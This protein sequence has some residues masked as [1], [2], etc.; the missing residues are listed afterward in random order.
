MKNFLSSADLAIWLVMI[1]GKVVL[2]LCILKKNLVR[3]LPWVS[4][5][6]FASTIKSLFLLALAFLA[7]YTVYYYSFFVANFMLSAIA[8]LT[9]LEFWRQV[10]PGFNLPHN[11]QALGSFLAAMAGVAIFATLWPVKYPENRIELATYLVIAVAFIFI[12][13]Y[14]RYLGLYW[15][16]LVGGVS[17][18]LGVLY[19]V[20]GIV[21]AVMWHYSHF[22]FLP[23]R[24]IS[25]IVS[26]VAAV[27]WTIV[28]LS[29]WGE[30]EITE[31][32]LLKLGQ[33]VDHMETDFIG[34]VRNG[35]FLTGGKK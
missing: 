25:E 10:L 34:A 30:R 20:D 4:A 28:I 7:S 9:L 35:K 29:P 5:Y 23:T 26:I 2:C 33:L 18:T 17:F 11:K 27:S 31:E 3:R 13:G 16:R 15:S 22:I 21:K 1:A 14:A 12:A 8:F 19:L 6:V 32:E 24:Y